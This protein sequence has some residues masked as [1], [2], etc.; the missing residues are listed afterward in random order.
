MRYLPDPSEHP[1]RQPHHWASHTLTQS[2]RQ[3]CWA[4]IYESP[5]HRPRGEEL[6]T[7]RILKHLRHL[8]LASK[9]YY[10]Y[11]SHDAGR[12]VFLQMHPQG[13]LSAHMRG[14]QLWH[15][16]PRDDPRASDACLL[17]IWVVANLDLTSRESES[18]LVILENEN[19]LQ[20]I[21]CNPRS[22]LTWEVSKI[23]RGD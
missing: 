23:P 21:L 6:T 2:K 19:E 7:W 14:F 4:R 11:S 22:I 13:R 12:L 8:D 1:A 20:G 18:C 3:D 5:L 15:Y 17:S 10:R 9:C 16:L